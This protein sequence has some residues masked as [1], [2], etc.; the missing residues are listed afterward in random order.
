MHLRK[1]HS[2]A[3]PNIAIGFIV[4]RQAHMGLKIPSVFSAFS[5]GTRDEASLGIE[6]LL[7]LDAIILQ[8]QHLRLLRRK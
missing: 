1:N 5:R 8:L 2:I 3:H 4:F 6:L 7:G